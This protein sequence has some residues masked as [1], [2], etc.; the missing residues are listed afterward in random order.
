MKIFCAEISGSNETMKA[1]AVVMQK[2]GKTFSML[3]YYTTDVDNIQLLSKGMPVNIGINYFD[4]IEETITLPP[5]K[6]PAT[7]R[8]IA[9]NKLKD[10]IEPTKE[11]LMAYKA[12]QA[13]LPD[14]SGNLNYKVLMIPSSVLYEDSQLSE[15]TM[16]SLNMFTVADFAL[17]S[18]VQKYFP[19]KIVFHAYADDSKICVTICMNDYIVY[20]RNNPMEKGANLLSAYYEY[21]NLTYMYATKNLKL[22]IDYAVFSGKLA[23]MK[24]LVTMFYEFSG[25]AQSTL[26]PAGIVNNCSN[27]I[28]QEYMIPISL[29]F[30]D[31]SYD[32]TPPEIMKK[33]ATTFATTI[34]NGCAMFLVMVLLILNALAIFTL[35]D[36]KST[37]TMQAQNL[38]RKIKSY[39]SE[40]ST[41]H[42]KR[43]DLN[44]Y[45]AMEK[46]DKSVSR[47]FE[48]FADLLA[49]GD[50]N[51]ASFN[52]EENGN[53]LIE[54]GGQL[55]FPRLDQIENFKDIFQKELDK[56]SAK[57]GYTLENK[58]E[59]LTDKMEVNVRLIF[60]TGEQQE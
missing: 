39:L 49:T 35:Y 30:L 18:L 56:I 43:F 2:K 57:G 36:N 47:D 13:M 4:T 40:V 7:F 27:D 3:K 16:Q 28:F 9:T 42:S 44:Y 26:I 55:N 41:V 58:T 5:V 34:V 6:D 45:K 60:R 12:N 59:F 53:K 23:D 11:Y 51:I 46:R 19:D 38:S 15:N 14:A 50:Y 54:I 17:C 22:K 1:K 48:L 37:M 33:Q 10:S 25:V 20:T 21:L 32:M 24:E 29:C 8:L 31:S 52:N